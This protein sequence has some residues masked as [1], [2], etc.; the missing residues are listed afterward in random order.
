MTDAPP[1]AERSAG[2]PPVTNADFEAFYLAHRV[3]L[4]RALVVVTRDVHAA[5]EVAQDAFVRVWERWDRV[6]QM[7]DPTGYL[8]RT[9]LNGW[10]Q[11][12]RRAVR[13]ARRVAGPGR[14]VDPLEMV[15]DRDV[16]A[17]RLLE[18]PARQR[19]ALVLTEYLGHHS[20]EAGWALGI[21]PGTVRR[22]ASKARAA[23]RRGY[24]EGEAL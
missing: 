10:F 3:R 4:F 20:A 7:E 23:L 8:Y 15:E 2:T 13:A 21:R 1:L 12:R 14:V 19:A 5:E 11:V 16:L 17:R 6:R 9:A 18:L 24:D 22:L